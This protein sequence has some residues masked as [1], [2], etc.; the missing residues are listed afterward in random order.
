MAN[1]NQNTG[2]RKVCFSLLHKRSAEVLVQG[3]RRGFIYSSGIL[4]F[5]VL[6]WPKIATQFWPQLCIPASEEAGKK[7]E[8]CPQLQ[9][10]LGLPGYAN[11][12]CRVGGGL[13]PLLDLIFPMC[14][15]EEG[16]A[17]CILKSF[18]F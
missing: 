8:A 12:S 16:S 5:R 17:R 9:P 7:H 10:S 14:V 13:L 18:Q 4:S 1:E 15:L 2:E 6:P 3:W 11:R